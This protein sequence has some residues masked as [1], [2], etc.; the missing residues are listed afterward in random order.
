MTTI[1]DELRRRDG[2]PARRIL[3]TGAA[4]VTMDPGL[5]VLP[6]AD[7]LIE[8]DRDRRRRP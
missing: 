6:R 4:I 3:L 7:L 5:G 1:L 2:D 8:G